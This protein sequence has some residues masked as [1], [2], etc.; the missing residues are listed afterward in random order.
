MTTFSFFSAALLMLLDDL[1]T[2]VAVAE[3]ALASVTFPGADRH[4]VRLL[5]GPLE[6]FLAKVAIAAGA[7]DTAVVT[8]DG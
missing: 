1:N 3:I 6:T 4:K 2:R 5:V 7:G 8:H